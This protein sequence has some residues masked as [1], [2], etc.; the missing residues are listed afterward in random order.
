MIEIIDNFMPIEEFNTLVE[1]VSSPAFPW[2]RGKT[3]PSTHRSCD[4][5]YDQ[6]MLH[7]FYDSSLPFTPSQPYVN[8]MNDLLSKLNIEVLLRVQANFNPATHEHVVHGFH[9]DNEHL[10]AGVREHIKTAILYLN[11]NN[12]FTYFKDNDKVEN[13]ANRLVRFPV[14]TMH[15]SSTCSDTEGRLLINVCYITRETSDR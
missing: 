3:V 6:V 13:V 11:T 9:C 10:P 8:I 12:G 1:R 15:A 14:D 4:P 2:F 7:V 5:I